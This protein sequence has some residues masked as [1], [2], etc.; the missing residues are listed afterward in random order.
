MAELFHVNDTVVYGTTGV[1]LITD[2]SEK[3][4]YGKKIKY[5][6]LKPIY[7]K[8]SVIFVPMNNA[9][10]KSKMRPVLSATEIYSIIRSFSDVEEGWIENDN[11]RRE[12]FSEILKSGERKDLVRMIKSL[13]AHRETQKENGRKL[14]AS[15][16]RILNEAQKLLYEEFAHVLKIEPEQVLSL[17]LNEISVEE[18]DNTNYTALK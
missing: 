7:Q 12:R 4:F 14:H 1:C 5:Y 3:E 17:I 6:T 2:I 18:K 8:A 16:E 13:C 10:L 11:A 9:K 15:D